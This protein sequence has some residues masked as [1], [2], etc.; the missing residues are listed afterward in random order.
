M[1]K[2]RRN[3]P[4]SLRIEKPQTPPLGGPLLTLGERGELFQSRVQWSSV[5][6]GREESS[7]TRPASMVP[8]TQQGSPISMLTLRL[9]LIQVPPF[10]MSIHVLRVGWRYCNLN[11]G[12]MAAEG[13]KKIIP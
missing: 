7:E 1:A 6:W 13:K 12:G 3:H 4:C 2:L 11:F 9:K 5:L 8:P 10:T